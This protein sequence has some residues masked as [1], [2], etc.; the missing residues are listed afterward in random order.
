MHSDRPFLEAI[1]EEP[2]DDLHRLAWAD[3][4]EEQGHDDRAAFLRAQLAAAR[5]DETDLALDALEDRADDLLAAHEN[6]WA[7]K[8]GELAFDLG[9][10]RGCLE[11]ATLDANALLDHGDGLFETTPIRHVRLLV[12][13]DDLPRV[14]GCPWLAGVEHL[15]IGNASHLRDA[16]LQ[17]FL[18]SPH[19]GRLTSLDLNGHGIEGPLIQ[20][21]I[22]TGLLSR[23]RK[24][25]LSGNKPFGDRAT[26]LLAEADAPRLE[27]LGLDGTNIT[28]LGLQSMLFSKTHPALHVLQANMALL[29]RRG[30]FN[31]GRLDREL[32]QTPLA[33][34]LTSLTLRKF[35]LSANALETLVLSPLA[36]RLRDLTLSDTSLKGETEAGIIATSENLS[37]LR[38]LDLGANSLRDKGAR[39]LASSPYLTSL[40][41][42]NLSGNSIGGPGIRALL[43]S[44]ILDRVRSLDLSGNFVGVPNVTALAK[45]I[46]PRLLRSL[47][48][49]NANLDAECA[50]ILA[51][52]PA[53]AGLRKLGLGGNRLGDEGIR[54]IANSP[55][56]ARLRSLELDKTEVDSAGVQA[57]LDTPRL[58]RLRHLNMRN[59]SISPDERERLE[60]RYGPA[61][62]F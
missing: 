24:L 48:L 18:S 10:S 60:A 44:P 51:G 31:S 39:V 27:W 47:H 1:R 16:P 40:V 54:A 59:V 15:E 35:A 19:L 36:S 21:L 13:E 58:D 22:G 52:S 11:S 5:L 33:G 30:D 20:T 56:L 43:D 9:W 34:R 62:R 41:H 42:S 53:F 50:A 8:V 32:L 12:A 61:M 7:G 37:G 25:D 17:A 46:R 26:R 23:L 49:R 45:A 29:F 6:E 14:A 28:S 2:D 57:L 38:R 55:H 4:L 3:W